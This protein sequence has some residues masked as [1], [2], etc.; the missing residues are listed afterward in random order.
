MA[1]KLL[2]VVVLVAFV[3]SLAQVGFAY[4]QQE[5]TISKYQKSL[6]ALGYYKGEPTGTMDAATVEAIKACQRKCGMEPTGKLDNP[7]CK[8]I[9]GEVQKELAPAE[10]EIK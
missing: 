6:R 2:T 4:Q 1:R 3:V 7:T 9:W 8:A 10:G 5:Q